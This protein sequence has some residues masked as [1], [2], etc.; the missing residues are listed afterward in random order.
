[1]QK[2]PYNQG[3]SVSLSLQGFYVFTN[4]VTHSTCRDSKLLY[5]RTKGI[6]LLFKIKL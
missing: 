2:K 5:Y 1:M 4:K 3:I 6:E